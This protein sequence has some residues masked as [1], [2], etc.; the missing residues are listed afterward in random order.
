MVVN[1]LLS[2]KNIEDHKIYFGHHYVYVYSAA[3]VMK[4]IILRIDV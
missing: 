1:G 4:K 3:I 2:L